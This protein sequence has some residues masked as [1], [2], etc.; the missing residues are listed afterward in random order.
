[1]FRKI[2]A[3]SFAVMLL[4]GATAVFAECH[5]EF[6]HWPSLCE[7]YPQVCDADGD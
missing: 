1:M 5:D 3:F 6:V 4:T 2:V 7:Q